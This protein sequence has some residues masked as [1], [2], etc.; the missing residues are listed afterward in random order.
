MRMN[1][2]ASLC[3]K[4]ALSSRSGCGIV[5]VAERSFSDNGH[6]AA[7]VRHIGSVIYNARH[8]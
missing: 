8:E 2:R 1:K 7:V 3:A 6:D 4:F 5:V